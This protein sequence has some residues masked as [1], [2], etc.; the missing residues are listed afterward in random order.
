MQEK[1][2]LMYAFIEEQAA[3]KDVSLSRADYEAVDAIMEH[4]NMFGE[5]DHIE[6]DETR[7][8]SIK[9]VKARAA[10]KRL[11]HLL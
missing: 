5:P 11:A 1:H 6:E 10:R 4:V 7:V 8:M 2:N 9:T 3:A